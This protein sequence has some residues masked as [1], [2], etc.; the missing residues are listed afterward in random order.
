MIRLY[1]AAGVLLAVFFSYAAG[2]RFGRAECSV[3][4]AQ[5]SS[6]INTAV[7]KTVGEINEQVINTG[8]RDIRRVLR[9]QY[10]IAE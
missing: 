5:N 2:V 9:T 7:V 1:V 10:T 3:T 4:A 8:V 6:A